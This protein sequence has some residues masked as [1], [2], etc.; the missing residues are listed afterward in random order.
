MPLL[1]LPYDPRPNDDD[2]KYRDCD[3]NHKN[4]YRYEND[5]DTDANDD[6][7]DD[8]DNWLISNNSQKFHNFLYKS[9]P[10]VLEE[11]VLGKYNFTQV[12]SQ[13]A[14]ESNILSPKVVVASSKMRQKHFF[15]QI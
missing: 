4:N 13:F 12:R 10:I 7:D 3:S 1:T 8:G 5:T 2:V 6:T 11:Q 15:D 9:F 14:L